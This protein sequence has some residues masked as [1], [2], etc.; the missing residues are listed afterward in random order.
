MF[1]SSALDWLEDTGSSVWDTV[2][3]AGAGVLGSAEHLVEG[4]GA[5]VSSAVDRVYTD[6]TGLVE[7]GGAQINKQ[8]DMLVHVVDKGEAFAEHAVD[9]LGGVATDLID[10]T[11]STVSMPLMLL[12]GGA[13]LF[14]AASGK[15]S[16][17]SR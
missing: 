6:A 17:F 5:S 10:K 11:A 13:L 2:Y 1:L 15:N 12:G 16:G 9:Q 8:E 7:W 4:A 3:D 14:L